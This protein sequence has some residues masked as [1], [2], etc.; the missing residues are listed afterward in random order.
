MDPFI[1]DEIGEYTIQKKLGHGK[2][3]NVYLGI[4]RISQKKVAIKSL[5]PVFSTTEQWVKRFFFESDVL[6]RLL[7]PN[8]VC[9][10][11][12]IEK[13]Q[14]FFLVQEYVDGMS[15]EEYHASMH[16]L[17]PWEKLAPILKKIV[18]ALDYAHS[19]QIIHRDIKPSNVM[20]DRA[21]EPKLTD[22]GISKS[23]DQPSSMDLTEK[24]H[25][26]GTPAFMAPEICS[27]S[28]FLPR[29]DIYSLGVMTYFLLS[30]KKPIDG[31]SIKEVLMNQILQEPKPLK[32][33][34]PVSEAISQWVMKMMAK[35]PENRYQTMADVLTAMP[36]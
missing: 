14:K 22:F 13:N 30:G 15:L 10:F 7:H 12:I 28:A 32:E 20:L 1:G 18:L 34:I 9:G 29:S 23:L 19:Q 25:T 33:I 26:V 24:G 27:G 11:G 31:N 8:I 16:Y 21:Y 5:N 4:S 2:A 6:D 36:S 17:I 3:G 35:N